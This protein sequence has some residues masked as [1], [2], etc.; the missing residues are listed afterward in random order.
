MESESESNKTRYPNCIPNPRPRR[1]PSITARPHR[2]IHTHRHR[3][4]I[5]ISDSEH[6]GLPTLLL[7]SSGFDLTD[8][9]TSVGSHLDAIEPNLTC[10]SFIHASLTSLAKLHYTLCEF[11]LTCSF[12][13]CITFLR[14]RYLDLFCNSS[15]LLFSSYFVSRSPY[16]SDIS[17]LNKR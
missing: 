12:T 14:S 2:S 3:S 6:F 8:G 5:S 9:L 17:R 15:H 16:I 10:T 1:H 11:N 13:F 4:R 7:T